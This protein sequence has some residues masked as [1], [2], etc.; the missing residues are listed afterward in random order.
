MS[1]KSNYAFVSDNG[2]VIGVGT[3]SDVPPNV[4]KGLA[5]A[6]L[7]EPTD[8]TTWIA[9]IRKVGSIQTAAS[10]MVQRMGGTLLTKE[11]VLENAVILP[12]VGNNAVAEA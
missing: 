2:R 4:K 11:V 12:Y 7:D 6:L 1:D 10:I 3:T 5:L 9:C 8:L